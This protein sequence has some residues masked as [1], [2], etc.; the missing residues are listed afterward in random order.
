MA[1]A[2]IQLSPFGPADAPHV[3]AWLDGPGIGLPPGNVATRW[4]EQLVTDP[5][6]HAWVARRGDQPVGFGRLDVGPDR[7]AELT[8]AIAPALRRHG[9]GARVLRLVLERGQR[10]RVRRVQAIVDP[11]NHA[12]LAFFAENGFEEASGVGAARTFVRWIHEA[13][14]KVLEIEG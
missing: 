6:V 5:R 14:R 2:A 11:A 10:L 1:A 4:A 13:D 8:I 7:V 9:I 12:A 3:V